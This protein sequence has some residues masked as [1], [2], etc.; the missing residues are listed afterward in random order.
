MILIYPDRQKDVSKVGIIMKTR[1]DLLKN[2]GQSK[3]GKD[4]C[5]FE[6]AFRI[7]NLPQPIPVTD[8]CF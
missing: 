6:H 1:D 8:H 2:W 4:Y 3:I 7:E 5:L